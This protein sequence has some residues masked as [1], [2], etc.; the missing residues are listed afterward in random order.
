MIR[1]IYFPDTASLRARGTPGSICFT[2][3]GDG[4][5]AMLRFLCPCGCGALSLVTVGIHYKPHLRGPSWNWNGSTD[6]P[7]LSPSVNQT[8]CG[9][10]GWLRDGYWERC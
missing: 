7:T 9:W 3:P 6:A 8:A 1:A 4:D 2:D 10:H 5:V